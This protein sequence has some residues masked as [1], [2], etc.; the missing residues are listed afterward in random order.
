MGNQGARTISFKEAQKRIDKATILEWRRKWTETVGDIKKD[1]N[2]KQFAQILGEGSSTR[3][4]VKAL[5]QVYDVNKNGTISWHEFVCAMAV[6]Q[7]GN[8]DEKVALV[9]H[10]FDENGDGRITEQELAKA[11][12]QFSDAGQEFVTKVFKA[13]DIDG[14]GAIDGEE[15][16]NWVRADPESY[17][18]VCAKLNIEFS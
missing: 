12:K 7:G 9:F 8:V 11:V 18:L 4:E 13:C 3:E 15:F 2:F 16:S 14:D 1:C 6:V 10:A 5:F 17:A